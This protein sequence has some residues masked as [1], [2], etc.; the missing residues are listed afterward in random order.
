MALVLFEKDDNILRVSLNRKSV[1]N[2]INSEVIRELE[3]G[4][5]LAMKILKP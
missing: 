5:I 1:L 2:A 3:S 4:I